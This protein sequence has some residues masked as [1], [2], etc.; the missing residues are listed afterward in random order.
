MLPGIKE[1][2]FTAEVID[3][4]VERIATEL[5]GRYAGKDPLFMVVM[6]GAYVF[7]ADLLRRFDYPCSMVFIQIKS[8][9]GT[10]RYVLDADENHIPDLAERHVVIIEDIVD[11]GETLAWLQQQVKHKNAASVFSI[12]LLNKQVPHAAEAD[13][14]ALE[15]DDRFIVGYGLDVDGRYRNLPFIGV[16]ES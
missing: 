1:V 12:A 10:S 5:N 16:M 3:K 2:V 4:A 11:S 8:Y 15:V 9:R 14:Y 6:N 13:L 7:A